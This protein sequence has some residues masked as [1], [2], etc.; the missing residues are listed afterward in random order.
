LEGQ[1]SVEVSQDPSGSKSDGTPLA[2]QRVGQVDAVGL[3]GELSFL[4]QSPAI[5]T[6]KAQ[7]HCELIEIPNALLQRQLNRDLPFAARYYRS[8]A[9]LI[10]TRLRSI[11]PL[12]YQYQAV[13]IASLRKVLRVFAILEDR[14]IDY[15]IRSGTLTPVAA[16]SILIRQGDSIANLYILI[17][18]KL[19]VQAQDPALADQP[20]T[21]APAEAAIAQLLPGDIIGEMS[22]VDQEP[23][24]ASVM[25]LESASVFA[26]DKTELS[27]KLQ[28]DV[29][30]ASR[31]YH[32]IAVLL[33]DRLR[34]S[35]V[36]R[37]FSLQ[38][39]RSGDQLSEMMVYE[40][41]IDLQTLEQTAIAAA[42]FDWFVNRIRQSR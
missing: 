23:T 31:F 11:F 14:D 20:L 24:S 35:L 30:F 38:S 10:S 27:Q 18:G 32:A 26:L 6:V 8:V 1:L 2:T 19:Q 4:D 3:V 36:Q 25:S 29:A 39:Y 34:N 9:D 5:A 42:R 16:G 21:A 33:A 13:N 7:T 28:V 22:F 15:F 17:E 12:L 40:D 37:G 41:E